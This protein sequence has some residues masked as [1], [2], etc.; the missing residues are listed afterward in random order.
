MVRHALCTKAFYAHVG[1]GV[2]DCKIGFWRAQ[3]APVTIPCHVPSIIW[4]LVRVRLLNAGLLT[5]RAGGAKRS[6]SRS[7]I[8]FISG[9]STIRSIQAFNPRAFHFGWNK[10]VEICCDCLSSGK[11]LNH[12]SVWGRG[13]IETG[14]ISMGFFSSLITAS[15]R[16]TWVRLSPRTQSPANPETSDGTTRQPI[17]L[18]PQPIGW[19]RW[20]SSRLPDLPDAHF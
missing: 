8:W 1:I 12:R 9:P 18:Q 19:A 14:D 15:T 10:R 16:R 13:G 5:G 17:D 20:V 4:V 6:R 7:M 2:G 11:F 3:P